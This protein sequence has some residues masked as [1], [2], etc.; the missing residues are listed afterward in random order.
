MREQK[1]TLTLLLALCFMSICFPYF[2]IVGGNPITNFP[3]P[4]PAFIIKSDGTVDPATAPIQRDGDIYTFTDNIGG[5]T[6]RVERD[7]I[8]LDGG[9][10][11]LR[12]NITLDGGEYTP[13]GYAD[14]VGIYLMNRQ[15]VTVRNMKISGFTYGIEVFSF[16]GASSNNRLENNVVTDSYYGVYISSSQFN[17]LRNNRLKDNT[18][19][20]GVSDNVQVSPEVP[21]IYVND[22]D[23]SNTVDDKP[24][25]Y[26]VNKQDEMVPSDA[27]Y[28]ALIN[29]S[30]M[31][32]QNLDLAHNGQGILLICTNNSL[33]TKNHISHADSGIFFYK[34]SNLIITENNLENN[35]VCIDA[36]R[37]SDNN[38]SSNTMTRSESGIS[39]VA[40]PSQN[41][42]IAGNSITD[43]SSGM[44]IG[45]L[46]NTTI[47][48]NIITGNN[49]SGIGLLGA[50][51][52]LIIANTI[53]S[54]SYDGIQLWM[55]ATENTIA[56]N[57]IANNKIGI[58]I[59]DTG[60]NSIIEN[61]IANNSYG[62]QLKGSQN[63]NTIYHN[64]FYKQEGETQVSIP[65]E[66]TPFGTEKEE[67]VDVWDNGTAGNYWSDYNG[68]DAN[69][70]GIGDTPYTMS[71]KNIDNY[72]LMTPFEVD[73]STTTLPT[74]E[75]STEP[76]PTTTLIITSIILIAVISSTLIVYF[77]KRKRYATPTSPK[78]LE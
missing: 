27:G 74:T 76:L 3:L 67:G 41:N 10:Y 46:I 34:S 37:I 18:H 13:R 73:N 16:V 75:P 4:E 35:G 62:I 60:N 59:E 1:A 17:V 23:S 65:I 30:N 36:R 38:I 45:G 7:N 6:I 68:T 11:T 15:G 2:H 61:T 26:W 50:Q 21:N 78:I 48:R 72:P 52:T 24:V 32:V 57:W 25:V 69:G 33:V 70:D 51:K 12:G 53:T 20:L 22:I 28:V 55:E 29:C 63:N 56:K 9:G 66:K 40:G 71:T 42:I 49:G 8:T 5:Y 58:R 43:T 54:N 77:R 31:T 44:Y 47:V 64:N 39:L 14:P 19:N